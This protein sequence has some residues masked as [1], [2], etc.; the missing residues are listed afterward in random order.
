MHGNLTFALVAFDILRNIS[1]VNY[2]V[3]MQGVTE[4]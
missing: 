2:T 1:D 3:N 4:T